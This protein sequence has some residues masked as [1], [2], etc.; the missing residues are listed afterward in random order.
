MNIIK[1]MQFL[2]LPII[3]TPFLGAILGPIAGAI[4]GSAT[5][6]GIASAAGLAFDNYY[7]I[8]E[9]RRIN[10][11]NVNLANTA[12]QRQ[13]RDLREAGLNQILGFSKGS[14]GAGG[15]G[16]QQS[17]FDANKALAAA[18]AYKTYKEARNLDAQE[19]L[20]RTQT[21]H[22]AQSVTNLQI[23]FENEV[24]KLRKQAYEFFHERNMNKKGAWQVRKDL[25]RKI[26]IL[27][28]RAL[29]QLDTAPGLTQKILK[30]ILDIKNILRK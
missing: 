22:T 16:T 5:V 26:D 2:I 25:E 20:I 4:S 27:E 14:Q 29:D 17:A 7:G 10:K 18:T 19:Q 21:K 15:S 8:R 1:F 28:K 12:Y 11:Q 23:D 24:Y 6:G 30:G 3:H 13:V 9:Q